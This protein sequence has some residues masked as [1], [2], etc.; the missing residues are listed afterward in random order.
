MRDDHH[1]PRTTYRIDC[2][3]SPDNNT[4]VLSP[5]EGCSYRAP[6]EMTGGVLSNHHRSILLVLPISSRDETSTA[7]LPVG[8]GGRKHLRGRRRALLAHGLRVVLAA[9]FAG[10]MCALILVGLAYVLVALGWP[11]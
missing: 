7:L 4:G 6:S 2:T 5:G 9:L 8:R 10:G 3:P 1:Q 11:R